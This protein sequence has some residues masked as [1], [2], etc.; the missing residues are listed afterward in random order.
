MK[1]S[2]VQHYLGEV[3][4]RNGEFEYRTKYLFK[5][6]GCPQAYNDDIAKTWRGGPDDEADSDGDGYWCEGTLISPHETI[7]I[8]SEH[9]KI[10]KKYLSVL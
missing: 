5:T 8:P 4:E 1:K 6:S 3:M 2:R 7:K 10:L 9:Y